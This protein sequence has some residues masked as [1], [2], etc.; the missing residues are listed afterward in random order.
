MAKMT[1]DQDNIEFLQE[2]KTILI[3]G[4]ESLS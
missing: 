1:I 3:S 2:A 4:I